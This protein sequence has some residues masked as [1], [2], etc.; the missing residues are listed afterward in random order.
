MPNTRSS[1]DETLPGEQ[2]KLELICAWVFVTGGSLASIASLIDS[3]SGLFTAWDNYGTA[4]TSPLFVITGLLIFWRP[5]WLTSAVLL[6]MIPGAIYQQGVMAMA[7][8]APSTASLYSAISSGPFLPLFYIAIFISL[9]R[10]AAAFCWTQCAGYYVQFL[11]NHTLWADPNPTPERAQAEHLLIEVMMAHPVYIIA[12]NYIVTLRERLNA[13]RQELFRNKEN[14][15]SMVSHE[16][17][18]Q[19]QTMLGAIEILGLRSKTAEEQRAVS[20]LDKAATQLQ[21]YL[22]DMNELT[23]LE[24]PEFRVD[25]RC[26]DLQQLLQDVHDE[27][28]AVA[29]QRDLTL[30]LDAAPLEVVSDEARL[31]QIVTNLVSNALKYTPTGTISLHAHRDATGIVIT[32]TDTGIGIDPQHLA[33]IFEPRVR[34][35]NARAYC[36]EGSGLGLTIARR[37]AT[38]IGGTLRV[39]S[40]LGEGSRFVLT[41]A[42]E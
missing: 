24:D 6:S 26:F 41:I 15:L 23:R 25:K 16:I 34:L 20:R 18:N 21:T 9:P 13:V 11:L 1:F 27:W 33:R 7:V 31:R 28:H 5:Q 12:L 14:L 42:V 19:L 30:Q 4:I 8:H 40:S 10:G 29:V 2:R 36:D 3:Q 35:D 32:V 37:L 38:S 39:E 17:R 22:V